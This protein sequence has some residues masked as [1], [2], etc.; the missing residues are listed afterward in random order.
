MCSLI[1]G[2]ALVS[3]SSAGVTLCS[4][5][6]INK[7]LDVFFTVVP[8]MLILLKFCV[9][10]LMHKRISLKIILKF[11]L[12]KSKFSKLNN[13]LPGDGECTETCRSCF[14]VNFNIIFISISLVHQLVNEKNFDNAVDY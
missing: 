4:S 12:N 5:I 11:T 8:C 9:Y 2:R 3:G 1:S 10:Q 14:N 13:T 6:K 7:Q